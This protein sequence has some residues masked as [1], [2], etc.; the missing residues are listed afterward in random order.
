M[1][2][3]L[4]ALIAALIAAATIFSSAAEAGFKIRLGFGGPLHAFNAHGN[5]GY[6]KHHHRKRYLA[7]RIVKKEK[8]YVAKRKTTSEPK[9]AKVE[10]KP[11]VVATLPVIEPD[12]IAD[13]ENSS[14]TTAA[15]DTAS[16]EPETVTPVEVKADATE[17]KTSSKPEKAASKLDCKKF[18][19]SVGMTLSVPCE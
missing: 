3:S 8:V 9:V 11:Q 12:V 5:G 15:L 2:K 10:S 6:K 16:I 17:P 19:A 7:R 14:I 13:S 4:V 18:F 1:N